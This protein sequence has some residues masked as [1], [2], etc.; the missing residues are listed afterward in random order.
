M[1]DVGL[2]YRQGA[3]GFRSVPQASGVCKGVEDPFPDSVL[4]QPF[5]QQAAVQ[6]K[7]AVFIDLQ[8]DRITDA[9][10]QNG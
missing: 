2:R 10:F 1:V 4:K 7:T 3:A 8:V 9:P 6:I 5:P